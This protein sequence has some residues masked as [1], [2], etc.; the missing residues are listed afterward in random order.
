MK[1][2]LINLSI[3]ILLLNFNFLLA[4]NNDPCSCCT[5]NHTAFDFWIGDWTVTN[6]DGKT[7]TQKPIT[8]GRN[9]GDFICWGPKLF[10]K[11]VS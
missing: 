1:T 11:F 10:A 5:E 9:R 6:T 4:Q 3:L 2:Q 7:I 8:N